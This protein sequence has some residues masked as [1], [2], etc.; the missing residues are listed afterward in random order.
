M[1]DYVKSQNYSLSSYTNAFRGK[2]QGY[3]RDAIFIAI[4]TVSTLLLSVLFAFLIVLDLTRLREQVRNLG[5]SRLHDFYEQ[6]AGPVVRFAAVLAESFRA[7]AMIAVCNTVLTTIGFLAL[8]IPKVALLAI[9]VFLFSFVPVLGVFISTAPAVLV[10]MNAQ[11]YSGA[12][13]VVLFVIVIHAIEA[14]VLNPLIYG[15]HLKL[16]P[17]LVLIILYVG[18][19]FFGLWGM[20]L[21]VPVAYYFIHYVFKVPTE[22][23]LQSA[24]GTAEPAS[25][26]DGN[27]G[28]GKAVGPA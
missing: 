21:G 22:G 8:G 5:R 23:E 19:H 2:A 9:I 3:L 28:E 10:A 24:D 14:Y 15:R 18:H 12:I 11:G 27:A 26:A 20:L 4:A 1:A 17:V 6:S 13:S 16:N 25:T 7:Q